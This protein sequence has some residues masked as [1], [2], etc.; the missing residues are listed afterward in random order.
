M[1]FGLRTRLMRRRDFIT[2]IGTA[3]ATWP[4]AARAQPSPA[5][6]V[7]FLG[8]ASASSFAPMVAAFQDGLNQLGY[9]DGR[10]V[11]V[12]YHWA[13]G[14]YD[15]LPWFAMDL[16]NRKVAA[17]VSAGAPAALAAKKR[18]VVFD[19]G[20]GGGSFD[21]TVAEAA[22]QTGIYAARTIRRRLAGRA[23]DK[24]FVYRDLGSM[25]TIARFRAI[26]SFRGIEVGGFASLAAAVLLAPLPAGGLHED[27]PH[28]LGCGPEEMQTVGEP[29][30]YASGSD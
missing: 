18:G 30:A 6:V 28:R 2:L 21:F 7:G 25:A 15:Q 22:M 19:I 23:T 26:V 12:E 17:I 20:H 14:N 8:S 4:L 11:T 5:P 3:A 27:S 29:L 10:N 9:V 24:P 13:E 1:A 16:V